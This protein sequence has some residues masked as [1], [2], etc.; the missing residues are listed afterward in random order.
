MEP[1]T[2]AVPDQQAD[3]V[4]RCRDNGLIVVQLAAILSAKAPARLYQEAVVRFALVEVALLLKKK[5]LA[6][7]RALDLIDFLIDN[8]A[9]LIN[10][11][12]QAAD[13]HRLANVIDAIL[14]IVGLQPTG[15]VLGPNTGIGVVPANNPDP[16]HHHARRTGTPGLLVPQHVA[17][18]K[19]VFGNPI[20]GVVVTVTSADHPAQYA[21]GPVRADRGP[22]GQP[23]SASGGGRRHR[24]RSA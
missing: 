14:C 16:G 22:H 21:A 12:T 20:P 11:N 24:S 15:I 13:G 18:D 4:L 5:P 9:N 8:R 10:P 2:Q 7:A 6:Q 17:P 3:L 1:S 19:D 23:G